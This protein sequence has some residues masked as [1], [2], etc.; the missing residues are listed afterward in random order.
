M[1]TFATSNLPTANVWKAVAYGA[2]KFVAVGL[3]GALSTSTDGITWSAVAAMPLQGGSAAG[4]DNI[5]WNGTQ[6]VAFPRGSSPTIVAKSNDGTTWTPSTIVGTP[7]FGCVAWN[8]TVFVATPFSAGS[9][10]WTS[11]DGVTWTTRAAGAGS[12]T[13]VMVRW[14]N[15]R[16]VAI[17]DSVSFVLTSTDGITWAS[18]TLPVATTWRAVTYST[19]NMTYMLVGNGTSVALSDD[20][21]VDWWTPTDPLPASASWRNAFSRDSSVYLFADT[22]NAMLL[23]IGGGTTPGEIQSSPIAG[24][25]ATWA[26]INSVAM[27][28]SNGRMV[29]L[30]T[31]AG[32]QNLYSDVWDWQGKV[33]TFEE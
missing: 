21:G 26:G 18:R 5:I 30:A 32:Q 10:F 27:D 11:P 20:L 31:A 19:G 4:W 8:G 24:I 1:T 15:G 9:S 33:N 25:S 3:S 12:Q 14:L 7:S 13:W 23:S 16:F 29:V 28:P 22:S 17:A 6:F 2:G